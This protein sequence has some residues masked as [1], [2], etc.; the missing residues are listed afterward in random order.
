MDEADD[1]M[2]TAGLIENLDLIISV[3]T[4]VAHLS[5]ALGKPTWLLNRF[6]SEW[7][8]GIGRK[9]SDW[10]P[11]MRIFSQQQD[12]DWRSVVSVVAAELGLIASN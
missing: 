2:D 6:Q 8:W 7:R 10:Y 11:S 3:D 12:S 4:A 1:F 9:E 5:G